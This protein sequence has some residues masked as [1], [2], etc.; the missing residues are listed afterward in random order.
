MI[1]SSLKIERETWGPAKGTF[2]GK[3]VFEGGNGNVSLNL[4]P[5][6]CAKLFGI[7]AEAITATSREVAERLTAE[8]V[9]ASPVAVLKIG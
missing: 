2:T 6:D 4:A 3:I 7:V 5:A 8:C 9:A 1:L